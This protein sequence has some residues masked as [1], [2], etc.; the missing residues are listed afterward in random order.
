MPSIA[1]YGLVL[2][3]LDSSMLGTQVIN[4]MSKYDNTKI[5]RAVIL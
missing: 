3:M 2:E 1:R 5:E 4:D